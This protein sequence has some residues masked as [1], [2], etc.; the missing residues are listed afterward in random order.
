MDNLM[1]FDK[2][3]DSHYQ[4]H[5]RDIIFYASTV[6]LFSLPFSPPA[7]NKHKLILSALE[8]HIMKSYV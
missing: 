1:D 6:L 5:N 7:D 2:F 3:I 4:Q 8:L